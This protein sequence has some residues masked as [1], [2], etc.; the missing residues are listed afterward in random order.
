[1]EVI[2]SIVLCAAAYGLFVYCQE[3]E[4]EQARKALQLVQALTVGGF[5]GLMAM[6]APEMAQ[7]VLINYC[8][9][10]FISTM[11]SVADSKE[12]LNYNVP[13][14]TLVSIVFAGFIFAR[15]GVYPN[16]IYWISVYFSQ[17]G[18]SWALTTKVDKLIER[19]EKNDMTSPL[20][21]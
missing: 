8:L 3:N 17:L 12:Y 16:K 20:D 19:V 10:F 5:Y 4:D 7:T 13:L 14:L 11:G 9:S 21:E 1:M 18:S 15:P 6:A 2:I